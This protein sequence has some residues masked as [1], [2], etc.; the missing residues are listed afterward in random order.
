[1]CVR[2]TSWKSLCV[3]CCCCVVL[4]VHNESYTA[5]MS[6][7]CA[8]MYEYMNMCFYIF[9][10]FCFYLFFYSST[11]SPTVVALPFCN[12]L[13]FSQSASEPAGSNRK[14]LDSAFFRFMPHFVCMPHAVPQHTRTLCLAWLAFSHARIWLNLWRHMQYVYVCMSVCV[15]C[16]LALLAI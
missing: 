13:P 4:Y 10:F 15:L 11:R 8:L 14:L 3:H 6:A 2:H 1:M 7:C 12:L 5:H 16:K 9:F